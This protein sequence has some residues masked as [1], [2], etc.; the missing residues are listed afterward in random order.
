MDNTKRICKKCLIEKSL[1]CFSKDRKQI[2]NIRTY[3]KECDR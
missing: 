2:D 1:E 3:C